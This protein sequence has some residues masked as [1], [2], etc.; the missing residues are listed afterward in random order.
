MSY[1][2]QERTERTLFSLCYRAT[3]S[4]ARELY[5]SVLGPEWEEWSRADDY[6]KHVRLDAKDHDG[7]ALLNLFRSVTSA[8]RKMIELTAKRIE[9][10]GLG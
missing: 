1:D 3:T 6:I 8:Y 5:L 10:M 7:E 9:E 4:E 2:D